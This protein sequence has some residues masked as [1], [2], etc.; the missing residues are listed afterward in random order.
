MQRQNKTRQ[1]LNSKNNKLTLKNQIYKTTIGPIDSGRIKNK[2]N[3]TNIFTDQNRVSPLLIHLIVIN[4]TR[5][6]FVTA[7]L[8][9]DSSR[10]LYADYHAFS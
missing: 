8:T 9:M 6:K 7:N 2:K 3:I 1:K 10:V 4:Y 5:Q